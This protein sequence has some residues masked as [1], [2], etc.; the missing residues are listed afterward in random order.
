MIR[1]GLYVRISHDAEKKGL[2]VGRQTHECEA[3]AERLGWTIVET[4]ADNDIAASRRAGRRPE[5]PEY[6]RLTDDVKARRLDAVIAWETDRLFRDPLDREEFLLLCEQV[7]MDHIATIGDQVNVQDGH[8]LLA[9]RIKSD[10]AAEETRKL[11][12]RLKSKHAEIARDGRFHGGHRPYGYRPVGD[13]LLDV[14]PEEAEVIREAARRVLAGETLY[15]ICRDLND[16]GVPSAREVGWRT[17]SMKRILTSWTVI[18]HREHKGADAGVAT[19]QPILDEGTWHAVRGALDRPSAKK[20]GRPPV[21]L[22]AGGLAICGTCGGRLH[23]QRKSTSRSNRRVYVCAG[24]GNPDKPNDCGLPVSINADPLEEW[25]T[26]A[27]LTALDTPALSQAARPARPDGDE[28]RLRQLEARLDE[29]TDMFSRGE[30]DRQQ[31]LRGQADVKAELEAERQRLARDAR[32]RARLSLPT[33]GELRGRW[34]GFSLTQ[35]RAVL[36]AVLERVVIRPATHR[37][38]VFDPERVELVWRA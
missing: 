7:R 14:V 25:V 17:P 32:D 27:I 13:G 21:N 20:G 6:R 11:S 18:G 37:G 31:F 10:V 5:R 35:R 38:P 4:Y 2:G 8:G 1:A 16:R 28:A 12:Q 29:W 30:V 15:G 19:W 24:R 22:L 34:P 33:N 9:F 36:D 3:L 23:G 26:E